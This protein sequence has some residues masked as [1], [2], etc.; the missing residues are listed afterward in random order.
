MNQKIE[1]VS[2]EAQKAFWEVVAKK[3][4]EVKN[5]SSEQMM[6]FNQAFNQACEQAI[7]DWVRTH[8]PE[9]VERVS[10]LI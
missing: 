1:Q 9:G 7:Y 3:F 8:Y 5:F 2:C 4:P 6:E 10:L